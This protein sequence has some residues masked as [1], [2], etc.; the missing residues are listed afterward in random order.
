[1]VVH[2][3]R[4]V[5]A[6]AL[7][8]TSTLIMGLG[9][10]G[11]A[12]PVTQIDADH[13]LTSEDAIDRFESDGVARGNLTRLDIGLTIAES[14]DKA[15]IAGYHTDMNNEFV[16]IDY[17][18]GLDRRLRIFIPD[19]YFQPRP[20]EVESLTSSHTATF[21]PTAGGNY[22]AVTVAFQGT[23]R[24][25]FAFSAE[26]G[27][28]FSA[29]DWSADI[30][31][32]STGWEVPRLSGGEQQWSYPPEDALEGNTT[33]EVPSESGSLTLQYDAD[34][35]SERTWLRVPGCDD[36]A[37]QRVCRYTKNGTVTVLST[38]DDPPQLRYK[39]GTDAGA[40]LGAVMRDIQQA[41]GSFLSD[42]GGLFG[43][44]S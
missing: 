18:E 36:P 22:T 43:G 32:Q 35:T 42:L 34:R 29:R 39:H 11:A 44:G 25:C 20:G 1:M 41:F 33:Y 23:G 7:L 12:Q 5:T 8:V 16:C 3:H 2:S 31:N 37:E 10:V 15:D 27:I 14:D 21:E 28:Y 6:A 30:V 4:A 26:A 38:A 9:A 40:G 17:R 19:D 24:A 13:P